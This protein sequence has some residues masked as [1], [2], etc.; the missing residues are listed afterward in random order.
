MESNIGSHWGGTALDV[1]TYG[2]ISMPEIKV[3]KNSKVLGGILIAL[4]A[5]ASRR[6]THNFAAT[7]IGTII[8]TLEQSYPFLKHVKIEEGEIARSS[9]IITIS[10][11]IDEVDPVKVGRAIE[12]IIRVV[13]MDLIGKAG[14]FFIKELKRKAGE[15]I[16]DQLK[17]FGVDL[18][19]LQTEQHYIYRQRE[20]KKERATNKRG[21]KGEGVSLLGYTWNEVASWKYD[22]DKQVCTLYSKDGKVLD[23]L[24]LESIIENYVK[25]LTDVVDEVPEE[26]EDDINLTEKEFQLLKMLYSRDVDAETAVVLLHISKNEF[27]AMIHHL[28]EVEMLQYVS[29]N[30]IELTEMGISYISKRESIKNNKIHVGA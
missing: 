2:W 6:T 13:Y 15:D 25:D 1:N 10:H 8:K 27:N 29:F 19:A 20:R 7:V 30:I 4:Y 12:A 17:E 24:N 11:A 9:D 5:V 28:L 23:K 18:A 26:F 14:L 22:P 16:I 3:L 21:K